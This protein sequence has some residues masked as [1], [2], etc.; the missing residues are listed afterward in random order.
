MVHGVRLLEQLA[1]RLSGKLAVWFVYTENDLQ[2]NLSPEM[3][4]YR[5]PFVRKTRTDA[6]WEIVDTHI[7]P[8]RWGCSDLDSKRLFRH[9]CMP[10]QLADRAYSASD[11]LTG[12]AAA[13]CRSAGAQLVLVTI[14]HPMQ[15]APRGRLAADA[16]E[17]GAFDAALPDRRIGESC[18][19]Y[20]VPMIAGREHL[21]ARDYKRHEG[22]HWNKQGHRR[23]A[24]VL[25]QLVG[26]YGSGSLHDLVPGP[27]AVTSDYPVGSDLRPQAL[28]G[29]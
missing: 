17:R 29:S 1:P 11:Y 7:D 9:F 25:E 27:V 4:R 3:R 8:A 13:C 14:P 6:G 12:R 10:G 2:D 15:L 24:G 21:S 18:R 20:G 19:R 22:I 26:R 28:M 5:A 23:M 16:G